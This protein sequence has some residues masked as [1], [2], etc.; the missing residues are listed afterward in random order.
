MS[1]SDDSQ[2]IGTFWDHLDV[3]RSCI[4]KIIV[5]TLLLAIVCFSFK[6]L[7]FSIVLAP[8][9][10]DFITYK[11][12]GMHPQKI[13]LMNIGLTEQF[14]IHMKTALYAGILL[15]SPYILYQ[16]FCFVS[17]GLYENERKYAVRVVGGAYVMFIL[18]TLLNYFVI[19]PMTVHFLGT[20]QV[21]SDVA[22]MLTLQSYMDTL[23]L[24]NLV[25]GVVFELPVVCWLL[26]CLGLLNDRFMRTYRRHAIVV[27]LII[28]AIITPTSD[29]FTLM[30]VALPIWALYEVSIII[31]KRAQRK[32]KAINQAEENQ[33]SQTHSTEVTRTAE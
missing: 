20:Y 15:A 17:P 10:P 25:M 13:G 9:D 19:F 16:I 2:N 30:V 21:A 3:L 11:L 12:L 22:N 6:D 18:G 28:S 7:L 33:T 29:V 14:M 8:T 23:L 27:I 5:A 32:P 26:A 1:D 4:I 31:V 24:M